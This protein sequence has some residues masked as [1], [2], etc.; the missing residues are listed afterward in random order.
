MLGSSAKLIYNYKKI[1]LK[2]G[3]KEMTCLGFEISNIQI[4]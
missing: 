3:N 2:L 4:R 1:H